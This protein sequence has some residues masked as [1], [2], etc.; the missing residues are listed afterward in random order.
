LYISFFFRL[1]KKVLR[2][3]II[4]YVI[5]NLSNH[6]N[7]L[8]PSIAAYGIA[9]LAINTDRSRNLQERWEKK[10]RIRLRSE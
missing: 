1:E 8:K 10:K 5:H 9:Y 3:F 4:Y 2:R 7:L 6:R